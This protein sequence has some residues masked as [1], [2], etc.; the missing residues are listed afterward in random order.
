EFEDEDTPAAPETRR[1]PQPAP[2]SEPVQQPET[3]QAAEPA[4]AEPAPADEAPAAEPAVAAEPAAPTETQPSAAAP[5]APPVPETTGPVFQTVVIAPD[6]SAGQAE[7]PPPAPQKGWWRRRLHRSAKRGSG[8]LRPPA[9]RGCVPC[10][11][12]P[13]S[14]AGRGSVPSPSPWRKTPPRC[15]ATTKS[16]W[17]T[18]PRMASPVRWC[19]AMPRI[20]C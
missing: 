11:S 19:C 1:E 16:G 15:C 18:A 6:G 13:T 2:V 5:A 12:V 9:R 7:A 17:S 8:A 10:R 4:E 20:I 3:V 14:N